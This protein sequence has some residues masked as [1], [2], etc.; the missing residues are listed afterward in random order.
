MEPRRAWF[1]GWLV[2]AAIAAGVALRAV[3]LDDRPLHVDEAES[4]IN[5]LTIL[6]HGTPRGDYLGMPIYE[7]TLSAA[8]P[9][10]EEYEFRD[11]S[12]APNGLALYHAWLPLYAIA[13]ALALAGV[14]P[15]PPTGSLTPRH[16]VA[17]LGLRTAAPRIPSLAFS[18]LFLL[19]MFGLGRTAAGP[20]AGWCALLLAA[21]SDVAV[22]LGSPARYYAATLA[23]SAAAGWTLWR[24][25][26][27]ARLRDWALHGAAMTLLFH[28]H[29]LSCAVLGGLSLAAAPALL[30]LP[31]FLRGALA[32]GAIFALGVAPWMLATGFP[33]A[34]GGI[35][36]AWT[37]MDLPGDLVSDSGQSAVQLALLAAAGGW[38]VL[39]A[40]APR[41]LPARLARAARARTAA[42]LGAFG[43]LAA[44]FL[45]FSFLIPLT[46][47]FPERMSMML[48]VPRLLFVGI[49][50]AALAEEF[51]PARARWLAPAAALG[52]LL[53]TG[54]AADPRERHHGPRPDLPALAD[55]FSAQEFG[56][57]TRLYA[58]P[59]S[60]LLLAYLFGLPAQSIAPVRASFLDAY[61]GEVVLLTHPRFLEHWTPGRVRALLDAP[62]LDD[63]S[64]EAIALEARIS[65]A[66][67]AVLRAGARPVGPAP[68]T[69]PPAI[70]AEVAAQRAAP[71]PGWWLNV[72]A[73]SGFDVR[74]HAFAWKVFFYRLMDPESRDGER[75]NFAARL[76]GA[77]GHLLPTAGT[78]IYRSP[79]QRAAAAGR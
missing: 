28:T 39:G 58:E 31:G 14:E 29:P 52:L 48:T 15:D 2:A 47:Y 17:E 56:P 61:P 26:R 60:Q 41:L 75:A 53:L 71:P 74:D 55:W 20:A 76:R 68:L 62:E 45:A 50:L 1:E 35:P 27:R 63:A 51:A 64:A 40:C 73:F 57:E 59:S 67:D 10:S 23:L 37:V 19:A 25:A 78:V 65:G 7:N 70:Q 69:L 5:A 46:S 8:W 66:R 24:L 44:A 72:P 42:L 18:A 54:R 79:L 36:A 22:N 33:G 9:E 30:R 13:A 11:S 3:D 43:W 6:E 32:S 77:E 49:L 38:V 34:A 21:F 12:Y 4:A 16:G